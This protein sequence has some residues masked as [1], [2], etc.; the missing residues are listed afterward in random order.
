MAKKREP[1][2]IVVESSSLDLPA[3]ELCVFFVNTAIPHEEKSAKTSRADLGV[4]TAPIEGYDDFVRWLRDRGGLAAAE[5]RT[6][7]R[8]SQEDPTA[9]SEAFD[10]VL[11]IRDVLSRLV[12]GIV[13]RKRPSKNDF[14]TIRDVVLEHRTPV[15]FVAA[16]VG[17]T[18]QW[19]PYD[20][21]VTLDRPRRQLAFSAAALLSSEAG[22]RVRECAA[23]DC[24]VLFIDSSRARQ[25]R[26]CHM[27]ACGNVDKV[28]RY[29]VGKT[30][31]YRR[32]IS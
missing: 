8:L 10:R 15:D 25:R 19:E 20:G 29:R 6:I 23:K 14:A 31:G 22:L 7:L 26:W 32:K 30:R 12:R 24:N 18:W 28:S 3:A 1:P 21:P 4:V 27:G 5:L 17:G 13:E 11:E 16:G 2:R 9:A